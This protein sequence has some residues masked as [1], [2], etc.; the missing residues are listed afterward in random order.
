MAITNALP[1]TFKRFGEAQREIDEI[2]VITSAGEAVKKALD[3]RT[4]P[5]A[6]LGAVVAF[7]I[8]LFVMYIFTILD[9]SVYLP[10]ELTRRFGIHASKGESEKDES[11]YFDEASE[12]LYVKSGD[13]N[14]TVIEKMLSDLKN[15]NKTVKEMV[16][17]DTDEK[18]YKA[19]YATALKRK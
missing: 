1:E 6:I 9:K 5:A 12:T 11:V 2:R 4:I 10:I 16:L 17:F 19:Y 7:F 18:L 14:T 8:T 15:E 3:N 13:K